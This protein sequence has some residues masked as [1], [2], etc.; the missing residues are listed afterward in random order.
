MNRGSLVQNILDEVSSRIISFQIRLHLLITLV[1]S[2]E[3]FR[4]IESL[5]TCIMASHESTIR[6]RKTQWQ[7]YINCRPEKIET[8]RLLR[9]Q[10]SNTQQSTQRTSRL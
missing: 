8:R 5:R 9:Q 2:S 6:A 4:F 10:P 1:K 3:S 7:T